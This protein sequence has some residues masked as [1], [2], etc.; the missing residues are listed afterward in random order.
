MRFEIPT[1][2]EQNNILKKIDDF[3]Y[4]KYVSHTPQTK[5][6]VEIVS[7]V[8]IYITKG[9]KI[10]HLASGDYHIEAGNIL[11]LKSGLYIM[12]EVLDSH[13]EAFLFF[14]SDEMLINFIDKYDISLVKKNSQVEICSIEA[15]SML[16]NAI[17]SFIPYFE[18]KAD[19]QEVLRLKFEELFLNILASKNCTDFQTLIAQVY[20]SD[21]HFKTTIEKNYLNYQT[22]HEMA[23]S[24]KMSDQNFRKK[25]YEIFSSTPKK[26]LLHKKLQKA[27]VMLEKSEHN[28]TQI[29]QELGFNDLSWFSQKFKKELGYSPKEAKNNKN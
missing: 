15:T 20:N 6:E 10:L 9:S 4:A 26:W 3:S 23:I 12:S 19:T 16:T 11:F 8:I 5:N 29:A 18:E 21:F 24:F 28:V 1:F 25:F 27:K 2:L 22:V 7:N 13:Y 14:Y 17:F